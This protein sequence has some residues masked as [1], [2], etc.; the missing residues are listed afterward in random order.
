MIKLQ[1]IILEIKFVTLKTLQTFMKKIDW[2]AQL[3]DDRK[4]RARGDAQIE[5]LIE[6]IKQYLRGQSDPR[7]EA[8]KVT[9]LI[10]K[11]RKSSGPP[12]NNIWPAEEALKQLGK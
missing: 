3:S 2:E 5:D 7:R 10:T 8:K 9:R 11:V 1:H 6:L 4:I 12:F